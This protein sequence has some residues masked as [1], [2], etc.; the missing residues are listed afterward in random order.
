MQL[1]GQTSAL[2]LLHGNQL[3]VQRATLRG[4]LSPETGDAVLDGVELP[5]ETFK[6]VTLLACGTSFYAALVGKFL[7]ESL[8]RVP[9][10]TT[11]P[12]RSVRAIPVPNGGSR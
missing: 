3:Q 10:W 4:R 8:A 7:V 6:R 5:I 9:V 11:A 12:E 1:A 2:F